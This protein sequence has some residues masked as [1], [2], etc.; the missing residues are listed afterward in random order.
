M[1]NDKPDLDEVSGAALAAFAVS[2]N[3]LRYMKEEG[4]IRPRDI[5]KILSGVLLT[6]ERSELVSQ[7]AAHAARVL[8]S[9]V[10]ADLGIPLKDQN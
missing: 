10:A 7:P 6:L 3:T 4:T 2:I 8:L 9:G 1:A 5:E